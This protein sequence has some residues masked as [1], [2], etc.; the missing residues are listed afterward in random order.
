MLNVTKE[1]P[2]FFPDKIHYHNVRLWDVPT[3]ELLPHWDD[4]YR[5]V[6]EARRHNSSVLVHCKVRQGL[7][8]I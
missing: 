2:N 7:V 3:A 5:F 1:I 6:R 8:L 4:T